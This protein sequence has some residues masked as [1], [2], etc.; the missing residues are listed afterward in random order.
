MSI[1]EKI[2]SAFADKVMAPKVGNTVAS[3]VDK[4]IVDKNIESTIWKYLLQSYGNEPFYNDLSGYIL[5]N[6]IIAYLIDSVR[7]K[8]TI[9]PNFR[10]GFIA[11]NKKRFLSQHPK[12]ASEP[13]QRSQISDV[14]GEIFDVISSRIN[15]LDPHSD[16]GKLQNTIAQAENERRFRED[17]SRALLTENA[18]KLDLI[19]QRLLPQQSVADFTKLELINCS[20][21]I[22]AFT[23]EIKKIESEYQQKWHMDEALLKYYELLQSITSKLHNQPANQVDALICSLYCNIALCQSN[24]GDAKKAFKSMDA[25]PKTASEDSKIYH[26]IYASIRFLYKGIIINH[27]K[28]RAN[29]H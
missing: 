27:N 7:G 16:L 18:Q 25:I 12:Y 13:I 5:R 22:T 11:E 19:Y 29:L 9:Q 28:N 24:L 10:T 21:E 8:S 1:L 4:N 6:N 15:T 23:E 3:I 20:K 17:Q 2:F 26:F 14:L